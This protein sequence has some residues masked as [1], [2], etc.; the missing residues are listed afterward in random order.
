MALLQVNQPLHRVQ[1]V[2]R[3]DLL[4][5]GYLIDRLTG[6]TQ[7]RLHPPVPREITLIHAAPWEGTGSGYHSVFQDGNRYC[8]YYKA[9]HLDVGQ[10]KLNT[11]RHPSFCCYAESADGVTWRKP[12]LGLYEFQGSKDNNI[13]LVSGMMGTLNV[14]AGHPAIFKDD[15]PNAPVDAKYKAIFRSSNSN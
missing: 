6:V 9:W 3:R 1:S 14:D 2:K 12:A 15:N 4:V 10:G 8:M 11:G 5:D 7:P 13:T